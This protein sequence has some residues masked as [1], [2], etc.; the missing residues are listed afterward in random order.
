MQKNVIV[1]G[2]SSGIGHSIATKLIDL[3]FNVF[4]FSRRPPSEWECKM[5][6]KWNPSTNWVEVDFTSTSNL[7]STIQ[8]WLTSHGEQLAMLVHSAIDYGSN[9][10]RPFTSI[11]IDEWERVFK[12]NVHSLFLLAKMLT[13]QIVQNGGGLIVPISSEVAYNS[14]P[15]RIDYAA[16]KAAASSLVQSLVDETED[17]PINIVSLLPEGMVNTPGIQKRRVKGDPVLEEYAPPTSF[18]QPI[19]DIVSD[20]G[21]SLHGKVYSVNSQG[22]MTDIEG[23]KLISNTRETDIGFAC[24][25][26]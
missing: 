3:G 22:K 13:P 26:V 8:S 17:L 11:D 18:Q 25:E 12:V 21:K 2:G 10:R 16:S 24:E 20:M 1:T 19:I 23:K 14:G 4:I 5:P 6:Q 9:K 15:G 7:E